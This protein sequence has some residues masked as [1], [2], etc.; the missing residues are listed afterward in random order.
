MSTSHQLDPKALEKNVNE[1]LYDDNN[2]SCN[3]GDDSDINE[4]K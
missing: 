4:K 1:K 3:L 2:N